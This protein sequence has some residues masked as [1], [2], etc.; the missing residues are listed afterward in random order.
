[1]LTNSLIW[2]FFKSQI[3]NITR[4]ASYITYIITYQTAILRVD[5]E[6]ISRRNITVFKQKA[7]L[8]SCQLKFHREIREIEKEMLKSQEGRPSEGE[9][10]KRGQRESK[11]EEKQERG[12]GNTKEMR[13]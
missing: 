3:Y 12:N 8:S 6:N 7:G 13:E 10:R 11:E 1:L 4:T 2:D 9:R 5:S